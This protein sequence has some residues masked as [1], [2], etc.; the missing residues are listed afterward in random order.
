MSHVMPAH[1]AAEA[2][3][4]TLRNQKTV[5]KREHYEQRNADLADVPKAHN[6]DVLTPQGSVIGIVSL[7]Q[8][9]EAPP[10]PYINEA[11]NFIARFQT[12]DNRFVEHFLAAR[13]AEG[14]GLDK[15]CV[16]LRAA[17]RHAMLERGADQ[18]RFSTPL[19]AEELAFA[20][21]TAV[22]EIVGQAK[23]EQ[24]LAVPEREIP[25][26][27]AP[28][29]HRELLQAWLDVTTRSVSAGGGCLLCSTHYPHMRGSCVCDATRRALTT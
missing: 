3:Q 16:P 28:K 17:I 22:E 7:D 14:M 12:N 23:S 29:S 18:L 9:T 2:K 4:Q 24:V 21:G 27:P 26:P 8:R 20:A 10:M 6:D 11:R 15:D 13:M 19:T 25:V 1:R 5:A